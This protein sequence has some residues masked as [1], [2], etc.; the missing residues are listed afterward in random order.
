M[1]KF[2]LFAAFAA[3]LGGAV[4]LHAQAPTDTTHR[5]HD[6]RGGRGG[7]G[8]PAMMDQMLLKNITLTDAQKGQLDQVRKAERDK[9]RADGTRA[10]FDAIR[11]ARQS[12]DTA[13]AR[14]LMAEQRAKMDARLTAHTAA[15]RTM[16]TPDQQKQLDANA[17]ELKTHP[18]Q[19]GRGGHGPGKWSGQRSRGT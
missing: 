15:I 16:L 4:A 11:K 13:T 7:R 5:T 3:A 14:R 9:M 1:R 12:G 17:A 8:G 10:D 6:G 19:L 2:A 18:R